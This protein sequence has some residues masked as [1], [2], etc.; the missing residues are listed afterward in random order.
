DP[1]FLYA[2]SNL[3][4]MLALASY[5]ILFEP[6]LRLAEQTKLWSIGYGILVIGIFGCALFVWR[7]PRSKREEDRRQKTEDRHHLATSPAGHS[8]LTT[9]HSPLI[10]RLR[11][12]TLAF[13]PSSL[14]LSVTTYLT[15]D[16]AAIPLLWVIPLA[17]YLFTFT[18][19]FARAK[20]IPHQL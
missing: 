19:A 20:L 18:L 13:V 4:S 8:P 15:T 9:H 10:A 11:W 6:N 14:M 2:A 7:A 1:Y 16:I 5:P 3:G 12:L 17:L